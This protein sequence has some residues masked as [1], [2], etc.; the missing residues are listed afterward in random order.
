M[1]IA[2]CLSGM[3]RNF[4]N[5][6]PRFKKFVIDQHKPDVFFAGYPNSLGIE[7]CKNKFIDFYKPKNFIFNEYTQEFRNKICNDE[8]KYAN[9]CRNETKINNFL[10][11]AYNI[12]ICDLLRQEYEKQNNFEYDVVVRCR[13]DVFYYKSFDEEQLNL[14]KLGYVLIPTEWD[15][16]E[17]TPY[18]VSDSFAM[19]NSKNMTKY[20][21]L[22]NFI[23]SYYN[24]G[25]L[26]H[27]ETMVG[28][29][30]IQQ[31]LQRIEIFGHGWYKFENIDTGEHNERRKY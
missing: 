16:K 8:Q 20:S 15:F 24:N 27:P 19:T 26:M 18:A 23:E 21:T 6:F 7:E 31:S 29:H 17:V 14:A 22:Y 3:L 9:F 5:T 1:K 30:I 11:Q 10:S 2:I 13:T 25:V 4:E 28:N 12:K